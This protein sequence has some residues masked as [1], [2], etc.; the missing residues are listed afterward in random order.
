MIFN[1]ALVFCCL[2]A[3]LLI[4]AS[5]WITKKEKELGIYEGEEDEKRN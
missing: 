5:I 2:L 4:V 1:I 3:I